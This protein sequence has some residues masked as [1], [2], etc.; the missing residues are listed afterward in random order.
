MSSL[1]DPC[2]RSERRRK[3]HGNA[4]VWRACAFGA[5][6][7]ANSATTGFD[8]DPATG[9]LTIG[10][11]S[12][13]GTVSI[14]GSVTITNSIPAGSVSGLG[15]LATASS[16]DLVTQVTSKSLA[17]LDGTASTKLTGIET[18]ATV[19]A[20]RGVGISPVGQQN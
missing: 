6:V 3:R 15:S 4:R 2:S 14:Y 8:F 17:N 16:V 1:P 20:R 10:N 7:T 13:P 18:G 9:N 12:Y 5:N 11:A 19:G